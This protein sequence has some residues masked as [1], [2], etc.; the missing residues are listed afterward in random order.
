MAVHGNGAPI[1]I[2]P[3][4]QLALFDEALVAPERAP[5]DPPVPSYRS[6][7]SNGA[8]ARLTLGEAA[9]IMREA[10]KDKS[11]RS[12]PIGFEVAH[13]VRWFR[14]EYGA[15]SERC[16]TTRRSWRHVGTTPGRYGRAAPRRPDEAPA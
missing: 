10:V 13:F 3:D 5:A 7:R 12:T 14:N 4:G 6:R 16:A 15:T 8:H 2:D 1:A 9:R 11:N